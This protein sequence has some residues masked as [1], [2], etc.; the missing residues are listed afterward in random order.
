MVLHL[1]F[2]DNVILCYKAYGKNMLKP[3]KHSVLL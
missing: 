1:D 2:M 3:G